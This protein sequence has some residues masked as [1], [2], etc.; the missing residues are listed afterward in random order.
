MFIINQ[1]FEYCQLTYKFIIIVIILLILPFFAVSSGSYQCRSRLGDHILTTCW[2]RS[3]MLSTVTLAIRGRGNTYSCVE[4]MCPSLSIQLASFTCSS[5]PV[6]QTLNCVNLSD[7]L[8][9]LIRL[10]GLLRSAECKPQSLLTMR[11]SSSLHNLATGL[12][13]ASG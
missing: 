10:S 1:P 3:W 12:K 4:E 5:A 9:L 11:I 13:S 2:P 8:H 6:A 7:T